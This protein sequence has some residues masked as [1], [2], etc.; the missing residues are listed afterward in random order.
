MRKGSIYS[1]IKCGAGSHVGQIFPTTCLV[2]L[3]YSQSVI[4]VTEDTGKMIFSSGVHNILA[5]DSFHK[6]ICSFIAVYFMLQF[7]W[8][9]LLKI[10]ISLS[11]FDEWPE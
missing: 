11:D 4:A 7:L 6:P 2:L 1:K 5:S 9:D 8:E 3:F 10:V